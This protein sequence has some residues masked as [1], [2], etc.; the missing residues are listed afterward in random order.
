M[1]D[2]INYVISRHLLVTSLTFIFFPTSDDQNIR[3]NS[4]YWNKGYVAMH[5]LPACIC[6]HVS[7]SQGENHV[8]LILPV[9]LSAHTSLNAGIIYLKYWESLH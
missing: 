4:A 9:Y 8:Y 1:L 6:G 5:N 7:L 3:V 2:N